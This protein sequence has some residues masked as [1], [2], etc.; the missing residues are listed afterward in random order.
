MVDLGQQQ[1]P[2]HVLVDESTASGKSAKKAR[3][4]VLNHFN[5]F[6]GSIHNASEVKS[7][8]DIVIRCSSDVAED[9][10]VAMELVGKLIEIVLCCCLWQ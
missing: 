10:S 1:L 2:V 7:F 9:S 4:T 5:K 3:V 6:L 8:N